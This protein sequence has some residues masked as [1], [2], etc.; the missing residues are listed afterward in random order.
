M[1][2]TFSNDSHLQNSSVLSYVSDRRRIHDR[3]F[4]HRVQRSNIVDVVVVVVVVVVFV[5]KIDVIVVGVVVVDVVG[6][7]DGANVEKL[8]K[9]FSFVDGQ[10]AHHHLGHRRVHVVE[11]V[12]PRTVDLK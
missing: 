8:L 9:S 3:V 1:Y 5:F 2:F 11:V 12:E 6:D 7:V 10:S 4:G